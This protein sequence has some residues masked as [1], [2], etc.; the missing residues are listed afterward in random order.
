MYVLHILFLCDGYNMFITVCVGERGIYIS[1]AVSYMTDGM[2]SRDLRNKPRK[3]TR[4]KKVIRLQIW[5]ITCTRTY[6]Y[7]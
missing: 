1:H 4:P 7:A 6:M 3:A 5:T 2:D